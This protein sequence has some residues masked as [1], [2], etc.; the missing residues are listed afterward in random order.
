MLLL[1]YLS[2]LFYIFVS[3]GH[4]PLTLVSVSPATLIAAADVALVV[5]AVVASEDDVGPKAQRQQSLTRSKGCCATHMAKIFQ[6][7]HSVQEL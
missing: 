6:N 1:L 7:T 5:P 3:V 4:A 2:P